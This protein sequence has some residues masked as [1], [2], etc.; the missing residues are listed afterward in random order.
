MADTF[1]VY[2]HSVPTEIQDSFFE[3]N[4]TVQFFFEKNI[5]LN[6]SDRDSPET[7]TNMS[8][9]AVFI[10][11]RH[12]PRYDKAVPRL[13]DN[14]NAVWPDRDHRP[15]DTPICDP[16]VVRAQAE[17]LRAFD[18]TKVICSPFRRCLMTAGECCRTLGITS[19]TLNVCA[20]WHLSRILFR[21]SL[22]LRLI[23]LVR[24]HS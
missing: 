2:I 6:S 17:N 23:V 10:V 12:G 18:I 19:G 13:Q 5:N 11:M 9:P 1:E 21:L 20:S 7:E 3:K 15:Y 14:D 24:L 16:V 4:N 22:V 8:M